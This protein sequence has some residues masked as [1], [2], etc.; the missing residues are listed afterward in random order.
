MRQVVFHAAG[1]LRLEESADPV[2]GP[3]DVLLAVDACGVC[4][5]DVASYLHGHYAVP[6]QV[7]GHEMACTVVEAGADVTLAPGTKVAVCPARSCG[8]CAYCLANQP[9]LCGASGSMTLGYGVP[10]GF[11]DRLL[12]PDVVVGRDVHPVPA[13]IAADDLLWC[14]PL[15]VAVRAVRRA[16]RLAGVPVVRLVVLGGGSVGLCVAAAAKAF[17]VPEV[18]VVEPREQRRAAAASLGVTAAASYE[19]VLFAPDAVIDSSGAA[20]ALAAVPAEVPVLLVGLGDAGVPWPRAGVLTSFA[21]DSDDF[22]AAVALV[23]NGAVRLGHLITHRLPLTDAGAAIA[24]SAGDPAA[25]KVVIA[26]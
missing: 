8:R 13:D 4:G 5:S 17:G 24:A 11:A 2:V 18:A 26:P 21:Y 25:V 10:G 1:D 12:Y 9:G 7:L 14:E 20:A 22:A 16:L 15:A 19:E 3:G 6:G 23:A